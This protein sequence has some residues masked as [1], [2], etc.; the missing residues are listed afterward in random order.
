[1]LDGL[2][3]LLMWGSR[4][5]RGRPPE[6]PRQG[7]WGYWAVGCIGCRQV[8]RRMTDWQRPMPDF[9]ARHEDPFEPYWSL[10]ALPESHA[11]ADGVHWPCIRVFVEKERGQEVQNED[12]DAQDQ[13]SS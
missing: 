11:H 10:E 5:D 3:N 6:P 8:I 1:M 7:P 2:K 4:C 13:G 12:R 9:Q